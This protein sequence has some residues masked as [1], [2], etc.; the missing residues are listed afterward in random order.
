MID[1]GSSG[2]LNSV[3]ERI[4]AAALSLALHCLM[5]ASGNDAIAVAFEYDLRSPADDGSIGF[6]A[7]E[8]RIK[9]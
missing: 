5:I 4:A 6:A 1:D 3:S 2:L 9:L 7:E 8:F